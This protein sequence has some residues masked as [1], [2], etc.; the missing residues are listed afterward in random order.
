ME[1]VFGILDILLNSKQVVITYGAISCMM[2]FVNVFYVL[3]PEQGIHILFMRLV[4]LSSAFQN[5]HSSA[6]LVD[7]SDKPSGTSSLLLNKA[8]SLLLVIN[9]VGLHVLDPGL[10]GPI[11]HENK[12][13]KIKVVPVYTSTLQT[14]Y[15]QGKSCLYPLIKTLSGPHSQSGLPE[16]RKIFASAGIQT[17]G[18]P[19][20]N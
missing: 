14:L 15:P 5:L 13:I 6:K 1:V 10:W 3:C 11:I 7:D 2:E 8:R 9:T 19:V 12:I 20:S 18:C 17:L 4:F 16:K